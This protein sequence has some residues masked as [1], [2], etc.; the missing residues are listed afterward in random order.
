MMLF[1]LFG[2]LKGCYVLVNLNKYWFWFLD[3]ILGRI[4]IFFFWFL[5]CFVDNLIDEIIIVIV[6]KMM[7]KL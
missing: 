6:I 2:N 3:S 4:G 5:I 1:G 7:I